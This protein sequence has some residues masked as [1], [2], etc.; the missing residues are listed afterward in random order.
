MLVLIDQLFVEAYP[1]GEDGREIT[2]LL[3]LI[4]QLF[5]E[6]STMVLHR[7]W[8]LQIAGLN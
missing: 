6:A 8:W 5:V 1:V 2:L 4:D 3:V 7:N